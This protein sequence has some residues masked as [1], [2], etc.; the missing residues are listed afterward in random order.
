[1][2]K[3]LGRIDKVFLG[4]EDHGILTCFL[5]FD[6]GGPAQGF[7]G[8]AL[9][10][11]NEDEKRREGTAAG[12]DLLLRLLETFG[13]M[14]LDGIKGRYAYAIRKDHFGS[15]IGLEIPKPEGGKVFMIEDWQKKWFP[16]EFGDGKEEEKEKGS[17]KDQDN[18]EEDLSV[19][20]SDKK[21]SQKSK[22]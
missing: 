17:K 12:M 13:V 10:T 1:M 20:V 4:Q 8:Y 2:E 19:P 6:F 3:E 18:K 16:K 22:E 11:W 14:T 15:I 21:G 7:G 9:D 5:Y